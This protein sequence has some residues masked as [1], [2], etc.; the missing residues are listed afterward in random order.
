MLVCLV[1]QEAAE[2]SGIKRRVACDPRRVSP[3][4]N[5]VILVNAQL[6]FVQTR[7]SINSSEPSSMLA[8]RA[9]CFARIM[10]YI[11]SQ[12]VD[13]LKLENMGSLADEN[14]PQNAAWASP[15][16]IHCGSRHTVRLSAQG[17]DSLDLS[18]DKASW[19]ND[20][21]HKRFC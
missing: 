2:V 3:T 16:S 20:T 10:L 9:F 7:Q 19:S 17:Y 5:I 12:Q 14:W 1:N 13:I 21:V 18:N 4:W 11:D 8:H 15:H 6:P